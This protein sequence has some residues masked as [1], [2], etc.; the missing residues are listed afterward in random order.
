MKKL[1]CILFIVFPFVFASCTSEDEPEN[2]EY[3]TVKD[4]EIISKYYTGK[5]HYIYFSSYKL[6]YDS[7]T[8]ADKMCVCDADCPVKKD[9]IGESTIS[10]NHSDTYNIPVISCRECKAEFNAYSGIPLNEEAQ[11]YR[12]RVYDYTYDRANRKYLLWER[13]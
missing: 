2:G 8:G 9:H 3:I 7:T 6:Y 11:G 12:I 1:F 5:K 13:K 4:T 10:V